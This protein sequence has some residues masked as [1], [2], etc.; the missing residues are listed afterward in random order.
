MDAQN[1]EALLELGRVLEKEFMEESVPEMR[2]AGGA[3]TQVGV[4]QGC[5]GGGCTGLWALDLCPLLRVKGSA[6][7]C[8]EEDVGKPLRPRGRRLGVGR[9]Q[10]ASWSCEQPS[11]DRKISSKA[12]IL[13]STTD[14]R[15]V[16][17]ERRT[18]GNGRVLPPTCG[19]LCPGI[20]LGS[21]AES[22]QPLFWVSTHLLGHRQG[23]LPL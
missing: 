5:P 17:G 15:N 13:P 21:L 11:I 2:W 19:A 1:P 18:P 22:S 6:L 3:G 10:M 4:W 12:E 20:C 16:L 8:P 23:L 9:G 14:H 7:C